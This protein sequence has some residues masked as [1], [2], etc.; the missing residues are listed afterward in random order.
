MPKNT[1]INVGESNQDRVR[2]L[3]AERK[4]ALQS[5]NADLQKLS[6]IEAVFREIY[7]GRQLVNHADLG[8][9]RE[10]YSALVAGCVTHLT[11]LSS[12]DKVLCMP[13][14]QA[15]QEKGEVLS[16][17]WYTDCGPIVKPINTILNHMLTLSSP[18]LLNVETTQMSLVVKPYVERQINKC[19]EQIQEILNRNRGA[20]GQDAIDKL[21]ADVS[22]RYEHYRAKIIEKQ[23]EMAAHLPDAQTYFV[24]GE[25]YNQVLERLGSRNTITYEVRATTPPSFKPPPPPGPSPRERQQAVLKAQLKEQISE[26]DKDQPST[27]NTPR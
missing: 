4:I 21:K 8:L 22:E 18:H 17:F 26:P 12:D 20:I 25:E 24:A 27:K 11:K 2:A 9:F 5:F 10:K 13:L 16:H 3:I 15:F 7:S 1:I 6:Q 14:L 23:P 19:R